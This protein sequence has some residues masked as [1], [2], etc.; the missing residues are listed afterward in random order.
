MLEILALLFNDAVSQGAE[1]IGSPLQWIID[2]LFGNPLDGTSFFTIDGISVVTFYLQ[3]IALVVVVIMRVIVGVKDGIFANGGDISTGDTVGAW[4]FRSIAGIAVICAMPTIFR[5]FASFSMLLGSEIAAAG[6]DLVFDEILGLFFPSLVD[7]L[8]RGLGLSAFGTLGSAIL[9]IALA[10]YVITILFT[11]IKRQVNLVVLSLAAPLIAINA[12]TKNASD[13]LSLL[14]EAV[15]IG[16]ISGLQVLLLFASMGITIQ[17]ITPTSAF[18]L[19][20]SLGLFALLIPLAIFS[21][22]K[23]LP[24]LLEK[25]LPVTTLSGGGGGIRGTAMAGAYAARSLIGAAK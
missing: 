23:K 7:S 2:F 4:L 10:Y 19:V 24:D 16:L 15:S 14:K 21:G 3:A 13:V 12:G 20:G 25:Y 22:I 18:Y 17:L 6:S 11:I 5:A 9:I 8:L 1:E